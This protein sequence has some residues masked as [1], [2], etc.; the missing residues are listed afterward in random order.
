[1]AAT[2]GTHHTCDELSGACI[3]DGDHFIQENNEFIVH[4]D[5]HGIT[6][7][8]WS[9]VPIHFIISWQAFISI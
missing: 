3:G 1:M 5:I 6:I 2:D 9:S 8:T 7:Q 4:G